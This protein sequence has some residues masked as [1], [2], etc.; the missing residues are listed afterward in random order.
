[1]PPRF[2]SEPHVHGLRVSL[3]GITPEIWR[4]IW[5]PSTVSLARLHRMIQVAMGWNDS[6]LHLFEIG[7]KRY[8]PPDEGDPKIIDDRKVTL[9]QVAPKAKDRFAYVYDFGDNWRHEIVVLRVE[10][11][12]T[13]A[14][15]P[16]CSSGARAAPPDDC[17]GLA[18]YE[19]FLEAIRDPGHERH[20]ELLDWIGGDFD[21]ETFDASRVTAALRAVR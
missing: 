15:L 12:R 4:K 20:E 6:H 5:V 14:L 8:G 9:H 18:G 16:A 10:P 13:G 17:G 1:M 3:Q 19:E 11:V 7:G 21:P 2:A